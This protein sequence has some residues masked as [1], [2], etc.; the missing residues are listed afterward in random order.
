MAAPAL[1]ALGMASGK[2]F[3]FGKEK[4]ATLCWEELEGDVPEH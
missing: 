4:I 2:D 1:E 3:G